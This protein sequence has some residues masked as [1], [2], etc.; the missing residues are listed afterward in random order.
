MVDWLSRSMPTSA[1]IKR[2]SAVDDG[3]A[4]DDYLRSARAIIDRVREN[5]AGRPRLAEQFTKI[6]AVRPVLAH[7]LQPRRL[8]RRHAAKVVQ[9]T[10]PPS[11]SPSR[12]NAA[13]LQRLRLLAGVIGTDDLPTMRAK[14]IRALGKSA[15]SSRMRAA[16]SRVTLYSALYGQSGH[17]TL[18]VEERPTVRWR[19]VRP[20]VI[21]SSHG[22]PAVAP[23]AFPTTQRHPHS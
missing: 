12:I 5:D 21:S 3:H 15:S 10:R 17:G 2:F 20:A 14:I 13:C 7:D 16:V 23:Q 6:G 11:N 19:P 9:Q 18:I 1:P 4:D 8:G 22:S